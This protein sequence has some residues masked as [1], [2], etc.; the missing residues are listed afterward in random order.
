M[1]NFFGLRRFNNKLRGLKNYCN[2]EVIEVH[3]S[4]SLSKDFKVK[5]YEYMIKEL[6]RELSK[7]L[8]ITRGLRD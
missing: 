5:E 8:G 7:D 6:N 4:R 2:S 1:I 3:S